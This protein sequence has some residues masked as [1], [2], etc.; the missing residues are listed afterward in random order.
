MLVGRLE[1][2]LML[3]LF[4]LYLA[5]EAVHPQQIHRSY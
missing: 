5:A 3:P 4:A 2:F 1:V